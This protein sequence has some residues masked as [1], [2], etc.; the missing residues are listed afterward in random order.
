MSLSASSPIFRGYLADVDCRWN[1]ISAAVDDRTP[2]ERGAKAPSSQGRVP[3]IPKSRY[4]TIDTFLG[5]SDGHFKPKYNDL[6]LVYDR[7]IYRHLTNNDIDELMA[8]HMSHLFIRD[9]LVIFEELL[10]Q[11]DSVSADHFEN[12]QSTNWQNV[13]FKPPPPNSPIGWRVEFRP[14]EVQLT[15]F[16]NAAFSVFTVLLARAL[17]TFGELNLYMPVTKMDI[18]MERAHS[19]DAVLREKFFFRRNIFAEDNPEAED[20]DE[21]AE[22][23]ANDIV[24]GSP[25][26]VGLVPVVQMYL[27]TIALDAAV[28]GKIDKYIAFIRGRADG[29]IM[30]AAAWMRS[31]VRSHP[32]YALDSVV[33]SGINYDLVTALDDIS[34]G[35]RA[36]PEL[37]GESNIN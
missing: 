3:V 6:D 7:D 33:T 25:D 12:I 26:F 8:K 36:A 10:D 13:R 16:E 15:D 5:S 23:T 34:S 19:R 30:T 2:E 24:N 21:V 28:R 31:F 17:L 20:E 35:R 9:P 14:L 27:D 22:M 11:D 32:A 29:S 1:V 4:G 18:N 37:V